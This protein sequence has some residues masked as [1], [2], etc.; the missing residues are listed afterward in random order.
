M[1][2]ARTF[3]KNINMSN[4]RGILPTALTAK[5]SVMKWPRIAVSM[6]LVL[7]IVVWQAGCTGLWGAYHL[8]F[9][10]DGVSWILVVIA[11]VLVWIPSS[12][13]HRVARLL[14]INIG[15]A[16]GYTL[17]IVMFAGLIAVFI[18]FRQEN[19]L[20]GDSFR[21]IPLIK[22]PLLF[23]PTEQLTILINRFLYDLVGDARAAYAITSIVSGTVFIIIIG[24]FA[25]N[26]DATRAKRISA[27]II[28]AGLANVQLFFCYVENYSF[29]AALIATFLYLG[30][31]EAKD[32]DRF[33]PAVA[34]F[35]AAAATHLLAVFVLPGLIYLLWRKGKIEESRS[36]WMFGGAI[37]IL[38]ILG[39]HFLSVYVGDG[40]VF[41]P[42]VEELHNPYSMFSIQHLTDVMNI[43]LLVAPLPFILATGILLGRLMRKIPI[44][45]DIAFLCAC[46]AGSLALLLLIDPKLGAIRDW[47]LLS[48]Y[49]VPM[50]FLAAA[51]I[52]EKTHPPAKGLL[53]ARL[54]MAVVLAHTVPWVISNSYADRTYG[55]MKSVIAEDVHYSKEYFA[56]ERM[57]GWGLMVA[58]THGDIE[59][60]VRC[61][62]T[63]V[64][65]DPDDRRAWLYYARACTDL[66][67]QDE[68]IRA[69]SGVGGTHNLAEG[70]LKLLVK[71]SLHHKQL[72]MATRA[73]D[74][75]SLHFSQDSEFLYLAGLRHYLSGDIS[76]A[77]ELFRQASAVD[78]KNPDLLLWYAKAAYYS[79]DFDLAD[80]LV[81]IAL[82]LPDVVTNMRSQFLHLRETILQKSPISD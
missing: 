8:S 48:M 30:W 29:V 59:E 52:A 50:A 60:L 53:I 7:L 72:D 65:A 24:L 45:N 3:A 14:D 68:A 13:D 43:L 11:F 34:V 15:R 20:L 55:L 6:Y 74:Y 9:L 58:D 47:D 63:R 41:S 76:S 25:R 66:G 75:A 27:V 56:A 80:S 22:E 40:G 82:D 1:W 62:R 16:A 37:S 77:K 32:G 4:P 12:V 10:R 79:H 71:L 67:M 33:W 81:K 49:G 51:L 42:I 5:T 73:L 36:Y 44:R 26:L 69:L 70:Q 17:I 54:G 31:R 18:S 2:R 64:E 38:A 78:S 35:V 23:S 19:F 28:F 57:M 39:Y 61:F 21:L 46:V